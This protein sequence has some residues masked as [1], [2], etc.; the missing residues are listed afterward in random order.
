MLILGFL[1]IIWIICGA[2]VALAVG[3]AKWSRRSRRR[4]YRDL[5]PVPTKTIT[6]LAIVLS[7]YGAVAFIAYAVWCESVRHVDV[8]FG[9]SWAAPAGNDYSFCMVNSTDDGELVQGS[10]FD[11]DHRVV[12]SNVTDLAQEGEWV[13]GKHKAGAFINTDL[14]QEGEGVTGALMSGA[15]I[16]DTGSNAL[17]L[18][19]D[20]ETAVQDLTFSPSLHS[21]NTYYF[22]KR[23]GLPDLIAAALFGIPALVFILIWYKFLVLRSTK[24]R[25]PREGNAIG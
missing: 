25:V 13:V 19:P 5:P 3:L 21:A 24:K 7:V 9:D 12:V 10:C 23:W 4:K 8:G 17:R 11:F 18:Y 15:F 16:L 22:L 1:F 20:I 2:S 14:V 6:V